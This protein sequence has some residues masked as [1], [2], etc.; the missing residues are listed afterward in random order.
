MSNMAPASIARPL[1]LYA[2]GHLSLLAGAGAMAATGSMLPMAL[3]A[4]TCLMLTVPLVRHFM[5]PASSRR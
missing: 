4:S 5:K 2:A 1:K 3:A